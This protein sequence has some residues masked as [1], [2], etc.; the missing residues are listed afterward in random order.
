MTDIY[1]MFDIP[2]DMRRK[3]VAG[4]Q[5]LVSAM[6]STIQESFKCVVELTLNPPQTASYK[7][8]SYDDKLDFIDTH[9]RAILREHKIKV[10]KY[11]FERYQT[12]YPHLHAQ[13]Y[14]DLPPCGDIDGLVMEIALTYIHRLTPKYRNAF[15]NTWR[16]MHKGLHRYLC[17]AIVV[18]YK[19]IEDTQ[20]HEEW[21]EY[22]SKISPPVSHPV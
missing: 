4:K 15:T 18:Q 7:R 1:D 16:Y 2:D 14:F 20:R 3:P 6:D 19:E 17:P 10:Y 11:S 8:L 13:L 9:F 12:G 22:I 21:L 5:A